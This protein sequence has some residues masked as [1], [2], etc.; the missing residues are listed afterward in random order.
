[1]DHV[2]KARLDLHDQTSFYSTEKVGRVGWRWDPVSWLRK[3]TNIGNPL[4]I[5]A[6]V[7]TYMDAR[8]SESSS[9]NSVC[10]ILKLLLKTAY[11]W[12]LVYN[13]AF[14]SPS[15]VDCKECGRKMHQICVLHYDIIW[16]SGWVICC[17]LWERGAAVNKSLVSV[18]LSLVHC[19]QNLAIKEGGS[20]F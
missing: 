11:V 19:Q 5:S 12:L 17:D 8:A 2:F 18:V 7:S 10:H 4:N 9:D 13:C 3:L 6:L 16:P 20:W 14:L 15:F 1:M